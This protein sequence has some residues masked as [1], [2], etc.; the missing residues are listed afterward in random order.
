MK[1]L[2]GQ[3][4]LTRRYT[5]TRIPRLPFPT[6]ICGD[7]KRV[8]WIS[9]GHFVLQTPR[10]WE[11]S[12]GVDN[13]KG[14]FDE[15]SITTTTCSYVINYL[16]NEKLCKNLLSLTILSC[17]FVKIKSGRH[18]QKLF[19]KKINPIQLEIW[20]HMNRQHTTRDNRSPTKLD[21]SICKRVAM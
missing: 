6:V 18:T 8:W 20:W 17:A 5:P 13:Y 12:I 11:S 3:Q 21:W 9:I 1:I 2:T 4:H 7:G 15:V 14:L 19:R 16:A 10:F